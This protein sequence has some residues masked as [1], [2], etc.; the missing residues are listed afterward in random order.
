M[1]GWGEEGTSEGMN[2]PLWQ[3]G[4]R[5]DFQNNASSQLWTPQ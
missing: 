3:R 4:V 1:R 2:S 5:G